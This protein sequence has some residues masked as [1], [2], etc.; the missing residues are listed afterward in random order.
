MKFQSIF[1]FFAAFNTFAKVCNVSP[2]KRT[3]DKE[4]SPTPIGNLGSTNAKNEGKNKNYSFNVDEDGF[5]V[6]HNNLFLNN[7]INNIVN[8]FEN[9]KLFLY[10]MQ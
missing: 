5:N 8:I 6:F 3:K 4:D 1:I 10:I 7:Y 9:S 2:S